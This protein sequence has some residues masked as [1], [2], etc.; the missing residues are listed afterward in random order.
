[1]IR[2]SELTLIVHYAMYATRLLHKSRL[3]CEAG[4]SIKPGVSVFWIEVK[5]NSADDSEAP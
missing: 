4:V 1:M 5:L 2:I 3:A